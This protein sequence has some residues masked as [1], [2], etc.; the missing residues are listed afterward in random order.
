MSRPNRDCRASVPLVIHGRMSTACITIGLKAQHSE[1]CGIRFFLEFAAR[2]A[3]GYAGAASAMA[4]AALWGALASAG[5][6]EPRRL[7]TVLGDELETVRAA[8]GTG[9]DDEGEL[10]ATLRK[11]AEEAQGAARRRHEVRARESLQGALWA[12]AQAQREKRRA[13]ELEAG[14][15]RVIGRPPPLPPYPPHPEPKFGP[16]FWR[17]LHSLEVGLVRSR[18]P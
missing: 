18:S 2:P 15:E 8:M 6:T 5:L 17:T 11:W 7:A 14:A 12:S 13:S 3:L 9:R 16:G 4:T 10:V 1:A